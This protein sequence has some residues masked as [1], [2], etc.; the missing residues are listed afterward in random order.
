M[1]PAVTTLTED[2]AVEEL[3][4]ILD[5]APDETDQLAFIH[6]K[7]DHSIRAQQLGQH[8]EHCQR[9]AKAEPEPIK[10]KPTMPDSVTERLAALLAKFNDLALQIPLAATS[11]DCSRIRQTAHNTTYAIRTLCTK[12]GLAVPELE[13]PANPFS[14]ASAPAVDLSPAFNEPPTVDQ[15]EAILTPHSGPRP[16]DKAGPG[17]Y[18]PPTPDDL[19]AALQGQTRLGS[20]CADDCVHPEHHHS[21]DLDMRDHQPQLPRVAVV[22]SGALEIARQICSTFWP[23]CQ[24]LDEMDDR[25]TLRPAL[26]QIHARLQTAYALLD[27]V[28]VDQAG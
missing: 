1:K 25:E 2:Q 3:A 17:P 8:I 14:T 16:L 11:K 21:A 12:H 10:E 5:A 4:A 15:V 22:P 26:D 19:W 23:L 13:V 6:W 9:A 27:E 20:P 7:Q 28:S 18:V 24:M